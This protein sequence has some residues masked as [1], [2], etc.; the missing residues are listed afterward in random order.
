MEEEEEKRKK[1]QNQ[2]SIQPTWRKR[3]REAKNGGEKNEN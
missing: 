3:S 1:K 2:K